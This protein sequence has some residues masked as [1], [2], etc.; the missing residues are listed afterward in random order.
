MAPINSQQYELGVK[1]ALDDMHLTLALFNV[2]R[3]NEFLDTD[4]V[5]KQDGHQQ[6]RGI[7]LSA[8]GKLSDRL[9]LISG[10]SLIDAELSN[11]ESN[12]PVGVAEQLFKLYGE[13]NLN[14]Y[15]D[16]LTLTAGAYYT[17][18]RAVNLENNA[19]LPAYTL[20]DLGARYELRSLNTPMT[21]T[22]NVKNLLNEDYWSNSTY[23]GEP[24]SITFAAKMKF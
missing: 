8:T 9:T 1:A 10:L 20:L 6:N 19:Y 21:L 14:G 23:L 17:G 2:Q 13:Y 5:Y 24:R 7:E 11:Y 3:T 15:I 12:D 4:N 22:L 16:N 18:K